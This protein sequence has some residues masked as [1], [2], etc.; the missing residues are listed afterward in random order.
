M[1]S[2]WKFILIVLVIA[3][4]YIGVSQLSSSIEEQDDDDQCA[5][6]GT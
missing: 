3:A 5:P 2:T 6:G 1:S 4:L